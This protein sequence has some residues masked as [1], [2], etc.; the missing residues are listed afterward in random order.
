MSQTE[1]PA[2]PSTEADKRHYDLIVVGGGI[3]G[4]A[5]AREALLR[6]PDQKVAVVE[7]ENDIAQHQSSHNS[8]VLHAG[9]YYKPGSL[10]A[11][12]CAA[13]RQALIEYCD[14]KG[15]HYELCGK[16]IVA[17]DE[18]ELP[19]LDD[20]YERGIANKV[21]GLEMVGPERIAEIEPYTRG[22]RAIWSP[23]TGIVEFIAIARAY[24]GDIRSMGGEIITGHQVKGLATQ[25][26]GVIVDVHRP[27]SGHRYTLSAKKVITCAGLHSDR[28]ARS[29]DTTIRTRIVPFRGDYYA[30]RPEVRH[31]VNGLIYPVPDL[32]FP[33]LGVH[34]TRVIG[35]EVWAGPNAVLA[36]AR[37]GY[38]RW[39]VNLRDLGQVIGF[40]GFWR[41]AS[42]YWR[43]GMLEMYRD[44]VKAAYVKEIQRYM[45]EISNADVEIGPS[46][47]RAQA[48]APTGKM[49]DD[50]LMSSDGRITHVLNAPSPAASSSLM[51]AKVIL[52]DAGYGG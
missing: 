18:S 23:E 30:F 21:P 40:G 46:G 47:V 5:A 48:L 11:R 26:D 24:A 14:Q 16:L 25:A 34:M 4:L 49:V 41:M 8:G 2:I 9:I 36:F 29:T 31:M 42:Q 15:I 32:R 45:P 3:V 10:K 22:I 28:I 33:F 7:K 39:D 13:G 44:Y 50:F 12:L 35:G 52:D 20:L 51:I 27:V 37:E 6:S 38:R 43:M 17:L 1:Q 19:A